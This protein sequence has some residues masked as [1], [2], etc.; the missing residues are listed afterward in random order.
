MTKIVAHNADYVTLGVLDR[1]LQ[2]HPELQSVT[3]TDQ[4]GTAH[5][6]NAHKEGPFT[7]PEDIVKAWEGGVL[8]VFESHKQA[9]AFE[10]DRGNHDTAAALAA[11]DTPDEPQPQ[12]QQGGG[13]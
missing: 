10:T 3:F 5:T 4:N 7:S 6:V 11:L 2:L 9:A 8:H 13:Y 12:Q 1:T